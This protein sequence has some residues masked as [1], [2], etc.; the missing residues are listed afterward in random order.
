[1][2]RIFLA[3]ASVLFATAFIVGQTQALEVMHP[4]GVYVQKPTGM[5]YPESVG[6]FRRV[7]IIRY[8]PDD[9]DESAGYNRYV[10][11]KEIVATVYVFPSPALRS[12]GSPRSVIEDARNHLCT[13]QFGSVKKEVTGAHPDAILLRESA[14]GLVQGNVKHDG[15]S[16]A[17]KLTNR[18][19]AGRENVLLRSDVD[20]FCYV[21]GKWTVEYRIDYPFDYD[22]SA[23]IAD[24]MQGLIWTIPS[25]PG[26]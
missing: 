5:A 24:F 23:E 18:S 13:D 16:A 22:A 25:E 12:V 21:G 2:K 3:G 7:S 19:F 17:Y 14:A 4:T 1:M 6:N 8:E 15:H 26:N 11:L 20:V 10:P 9:S